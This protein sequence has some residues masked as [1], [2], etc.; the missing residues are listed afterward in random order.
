VSSTKEMHLRL[1]SL[2]VLGD[3][4]VFVAFAILG[5]IEHGVAVGQALFRTALPFAIVWFAASLWLGGYRTFALRNFKETAW[6]IPLIWF[7][8]WLVALLARAL[9][10]DRPIILAFALVSLGVQGLLLVGWRCVFIVIIR[11]LS[12]H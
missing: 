7:L 4:G 11:R 6:K 12:S 10:Y 9:L 5:N 8:C 3:F 1:I 2:A